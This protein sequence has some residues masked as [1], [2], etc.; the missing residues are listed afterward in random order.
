MSSM[1]DTTD[2]LKSVNDNLKLL[3]Q[4]LKALQD[5]SNRLLWESR[6]MKFFSFIEWV[7]SWGYVEW[8]VLAATFALLIHFKNNR[9]KE[10]KRIEEEAKV[11]REK[12]RLFCKKCDHKFC[13]A[14]FKK[15][16][17]TR[18][19]YMEPSRSLGGGAYTMSYPTFGKKYHYVE[20]KCK[21]GC[22][23]HCK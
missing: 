12:A 23:C 15:G 21:T 22:C 11:A 4:E 9:E 18:G 1:T 20:K 6:K 17:Y 14:L 16:E 2:K 8:T 7:Q 10:K 19:F 13:G 5:E 3:N